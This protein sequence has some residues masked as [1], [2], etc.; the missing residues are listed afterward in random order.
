MFRV[1][2]VCPAL[3]LVGIAAIAAD[4]ARAASFPLNL[5]TD[6]SLGTI[7]S[8][9]DASNNPGKQWTSAAIT[10]PSITLNQGDDV[11]VN[12]SFSGG[13]ALLFQGGA[14]LSGNQ[15]LGF[16]L[17]PLAPGTTDGESSTLTSLI[18][19]V[20][21]LD[22]TLPITNMG[23]SSGR[24]GGTILATLTN[25]SFQFNGFEI[26]TTYT[27]LTGGPVTLSGVRLDAESTNV[28][29]VPEPSTA[30]LLATGALGLA[31][32]RHRARGASLSQTMN[33]ER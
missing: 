12:I 2:G 9:V 20:G 32:R 28:A 26:H 21:S 17:Q 31:V 14:F 13:L 29:V 19:V 3:L 8:V 1:R 22:A 24:I 33:R 10:F 16:T 5:S 7:Q 4:R 18:G 15:V 30:L 27:S 23:T 11:T 25:T 6:P